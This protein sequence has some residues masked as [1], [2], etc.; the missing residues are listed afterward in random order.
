MYAPM[1]RI[2]TGW[3]LDAFASASNPSTQLVS[4]PCRR[5]CASET[6]SITP[7]TSYRGTRHRLGHHGLVRS[8][9]PTIVSHVRHRE[10]NTSGK[11][12]QQIAAPHAAPV[13]EISPQ[14]WRE[15]GGS[16]GLVDNGS[17]AATPQARPS[18]TESTQVAAHGQA[19]H[20]ARG[21]TPIVESMRAR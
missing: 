18:V 4:N 3:K 5:A 15:R 2:D 9:V 14:R 1:P 13:A 7:S 16:P 8:A 6:A 17:E 12:Q 10:Q 19:H 21:S 20:Q 11:G